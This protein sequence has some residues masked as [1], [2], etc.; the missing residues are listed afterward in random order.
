MITMLPGMLAICATWVVLGSVVS[1]I[2]LLVYRAFGLRP[3]RADQFLVAFWI[4]W[5]V[6]LALGQLWHLVLPV[7]HAFVAIMAVV[8]LLG[9]AAHRRELLRLLR[10]P[11]RAKVVFVCACGLIA[12]WLANRAMGPISVWDAGLYHMTAIR[13]AFSHPIVPGLA[14]L[15][16]RLGFNSSYFL[17]LASTGVGP[18]TGKA[19]HIGPGLLLCVFSAQAL[20]GA[21]RLLRR[22][23][24]GS[25]HHLLG[26]MLLGPVMRTAYRHGA[27]TS[28]D[29]PVFVLGAVAGVHLC[30]LL[31][32]K[33]Q[34]GRN[35]LF[36]TFFIVAVCAAGVAVKL[37]FA[38]FGLL[39]AAIALGKLVAVDVRS[40]G[41]ARAARHLV[42]PVGVA[43]A[44]L[45]P[46]MARGV[47]LSGYVAYP[48]RIGAFDVSWR[49]PKY[50]A[51]REQVAI[52]SWA[53]KPGD[54]DFA[55]VASSWD[56][57]KPWTKRVTGDFD[58]VAPL[59]IAALGAGAGLVTARARRA[60]G[61]SYVLL[62]PPAAGLVYWFLTAPAPRFA[63]ASFWFLGAGGAFVACR[64]WAGISHVRTGALFALVVTLMLV[65]VARPRRHSLYVKPGPEHGFHPIPVVEMETFVT[66]SGLE[67][68]VPPKG[69]RSWDAPL[70]CTPHPRPE[71]RLRRTGNL[72]SGFVTRPS[73]STRLPAES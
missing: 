54:K 26:L 70:P 13:W 43:V 49:L 59:I 38:V 29:L 44:I 14:N 6:V 2:G 16:G 8:G 4:G 66:D 48:S 12:L 72:R 35:A 25:P 32:A 37:S 55:K 20:L 61:L 46:W 34:D 40:V 71:L 19:H 62:L 27:G 5:V 53:R 51:R 9:L 7:G 69:R 47:V 57:L 42:C 41:V 58:V 11:R 68:L 56:W 18:W 24:A 3:A 67:L 23:A 60:A 31:L 64:A 73:S 33:K 15:H 21:F 10:A 30:K 1:G 65:P 63:G 17:M 50:R 36:D 52:T 22:E 39:C 28:P 45:V